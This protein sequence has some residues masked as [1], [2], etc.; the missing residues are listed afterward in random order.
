MVD[1][2]FISKVRFGVQLYGTVRTANTD[3]ECQDLRAIQLVQNKLLRSLNN[4]K[5][6]DRVSTAYL[7]EKFNMLS[8]NQINAQ[9]KLLE[10]WKALNVPKYPLK[11][12]SNQKT[13]KE[14]E[15]GLTK[16]KDH[17]I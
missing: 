6:S 3:T 1:G 13:K 4:T 10:V 17:V 5:L 15:R 11:S 7:L 9:S 8:V 12:N 2:I 14:P 16:I